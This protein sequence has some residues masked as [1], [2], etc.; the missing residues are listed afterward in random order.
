MQLY[1]TH[2]DT[3]KDEPPSYTVSLNGNGAFTGLLYAPEVDYR[4]N[5]GGGFGFSQGSVVAKDITFN[6][7]PG[8]FHYD[9]ALENFSGPFES[10]SNTFTLSNY[11]LL[12]AGKFTPSAG[13]EAVIGNVDYDAL[14]DSLF[15]AP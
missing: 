13:A 14:F 12:K 9:E 3:G 8:P 4:K 5:G 7:S 10:L 1:G 6:G 11:E 2:P 15:D